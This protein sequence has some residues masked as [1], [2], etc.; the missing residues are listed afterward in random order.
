M[1]RDKTYNIM[2]YKN[3]NVD[4]VYMG[5][6]YIDPHDDP[7]TFHKKYST[8]SIECVIN[9]EGGGGNVILTLDDNGEYMFMTKEHFIP[10]SEWREMKINK[11]LDE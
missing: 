1:E 9:Y 2:K 5:R 8:Y 10:L 11:A 3:R 4:V 6:D 7:Y